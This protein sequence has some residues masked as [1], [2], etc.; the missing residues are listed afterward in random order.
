MCNLKLI[1]LNDKTHLRVE[2]GFQGIFK[3]SPV[4]LVDKVEEGATDKIILQ[5]S[6]ERGHCV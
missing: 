4:T 6:E 1:F 2:M 5:V 3:N